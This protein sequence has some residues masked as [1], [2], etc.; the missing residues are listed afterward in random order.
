ME[1][2]HLAHAMKNHLQADQ[3]QPIPEIERALIWAYQNTYAY[4]EAA[5]NAYCAKHGRQ[6][7]MDQAYYNLI[8]IEDAT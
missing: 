6:W 2:W 3:A 5:L 4:A 1:C 7:S 8:K